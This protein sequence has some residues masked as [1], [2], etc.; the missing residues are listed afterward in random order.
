MLAAWSSVKSSNMNLAARIA[1]EIVLMEY[2]QERSDCFELAN[3]KLKII[4]S[5]RSFSDLGVIISW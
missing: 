3:A 5:V 1:I 2:E 4:Q